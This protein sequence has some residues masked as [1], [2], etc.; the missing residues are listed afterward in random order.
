ML[1]F[2]FKYF[3]IWTALPYVFCTREVRR[4]DA[5]NDVSLI[6]I[7]YR[8]I[9]GVN[10]LKMHRLALAWL[11]WELTLES[12]TWWLCHRSLNVTKIKVISSGTPQLSFQTLATSS[13]SIARIT[14]HAL[15]TSTSQLT[16]LKAT[17]VI[18]CLRRNSER[19]R[20]TFAMV[21]IIPKTGWCSGWT[22]RRLSSIHRLKSAVPCLI[23]A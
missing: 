7:V 16:T 19:S 18:Q 17:Q 4:D 10:W 21:A 13:E 15:A 3:L 23:S 1:N 8:N 9:L 20:W 6:L 11:S 14:F 2:F 12:T 22:E 5:G